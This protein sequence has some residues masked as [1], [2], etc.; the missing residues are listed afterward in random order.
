MTHCT[1]QLWNFNQYHLLLHLLNC[2]DIKSFISGH[3]QG[4][5]SMSVIQYQKKQH[6]KK[7]TTSKV[8][9]ER[10]K[11]LH[12]KEHQK[13]ET[14]NVL[15]FFY[16]IGNIIEHWESP[17]LGKLSMFWYYLWHL[18]RSERWKSNLS[19]IKILTNWFYLWHKYL[20]HFDVKNQS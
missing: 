7:N 2:L 17:L 13:S 3:R 15:I 14:F 5:K 8:W 19:D 4:L 6:K 16:V 10:W 20:W 9:S 18:I 11:S 12:Q 1:M